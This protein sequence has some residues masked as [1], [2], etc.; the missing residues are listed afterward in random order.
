MF[1]I[2]INFRMCLDFVC[3][4]SCKY[5]LNENIKLASRRQTQPWEDAAW[6][7]VF[8][9]YNVIPA[10]LLNMGEIVITLIISVGDNNDIVLDIRTIRYA[11]QSL[12]FICAS[13]G[14]NNRV[15]IKSV[16]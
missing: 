7:Q 6:A 15:N 13:A 3:L 12:M 2:S 5:T 8:N 11:N 1:N 14:L 9:P 4:L 10:L 16:A